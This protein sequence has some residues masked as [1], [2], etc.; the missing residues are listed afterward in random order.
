MTTIE[1]VDSWRRTGIISEGQHQALSGLVKKERF[2]VFVELNALLYIGVISI[3]GGLGWTFKT[4]FTNLGDAFIIGLLSTLFIASLYYCFT[5]GRPYAHEEVESPNLVFD[6]VLYFA[7]LIWAVEIG[8]I[9]S[10][11]Q[12]LQSSWDNY[13]LF[14]ALLF[15]I[16]AYRFDNRF[17]LSLALS[18]L[19]GWFGFRVSRFQL[20]ANTETLRMTAFAY[21]SVVLAAGTGLRRLGIKK[22]FL[23]TYL[24][25]GANVLFVAALSGVDPATNDRGYLLLLLTLCVAASVLGFRFKSFAFVA[26]GVVYGYFGVSREVL[27]GIYDEKAILTYFVIT[28][29]VVVVSLALLARRLEREG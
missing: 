21:S 7:C 11:F 4:Y 26:Y 13:L 12:L 16:F 5:R 27:H 24:H 29:T 17:V 25:V 14:S 18:S 3:A 15:F 22:H 6:Y 8:Y 10:R 9:E 28:G 1:R 23:Q 20:L 19:A 2:S